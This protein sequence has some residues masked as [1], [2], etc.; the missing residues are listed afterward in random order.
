MSAADN[1]LLASYSG[2]AN[3]REDVVL[4]VSIN[5]NTLSDSQLFNVTVSPNESL[6]KSQATTENAAVDGQKDTSSLSSLSLQLS[7]SAAGAAAR[8]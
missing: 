6:T 7:E 1:D 5:S 8:D 4:V 2:M 3:N